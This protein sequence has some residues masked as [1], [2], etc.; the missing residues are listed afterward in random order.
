MSRPEFTCEVRVQYL[1]EQSGRVLL[2]GGPPV[3]RIEHDM[4]NGAVASPKCRDESWKVLRAI[5]VIE[6]A[7]PSDE[8][9]QRR[10]QFEGTDR[11]PYA[12][13]KHIG[14]HA[15]V[16]GR[17]VESTRLSP[18]LSRLAPNRRVGAFLSSIGA[19]HF[20]VLSIGR[21]ADPDLFSGR[22]QRG[23]E[24]RQRRKRRRGSR[25][26]WSG[27]CVAVASCDRKNTVRCRLFPIILV[28]SKLRNS[29][30]YALFATV[31]K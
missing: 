5:I 17:N 29:S 24:Q 1:A 22:R 6:A 8:R 7:S 31:L 23:R 25:R 2:G 16:I 27:C 11:T 20:V 26:R 30:I 21:Q 3:H 12:G 9:R 15:E 28:D 19:P 10:H 13:F 14:G 4:S 18:L